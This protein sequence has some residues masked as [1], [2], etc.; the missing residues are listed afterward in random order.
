VCKECLDAGAEPFQLTSADFDKDPE[1]VP[2]M[3]KVYH[4]TGPARRISF[5]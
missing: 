4:V 1:P 2:Y 5:E 3:K